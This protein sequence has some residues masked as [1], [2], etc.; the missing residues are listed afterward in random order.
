MVT[1][2]GLAETLYELETGQPYLLIDELTCASSGRAAAAATS[3]KAR[4]SLD[5]SLELFGYLQARAEPEPI[6]VAP[7]SR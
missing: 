1:I 6:G 3:R 2:E 7:G 4:R 5:V